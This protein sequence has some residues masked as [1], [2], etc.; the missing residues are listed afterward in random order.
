V[1]T[2]PRG[3]RGA[4]HGP[5]FVVSGLDFAKSIACAI[6]SRTGHVKGC[7]TSDS[8]R[9]SLNVP[10]SCS[11]R[12]AMSDAQRRSRTS[13]GGERLKPSTPVAERGALTAAPPSA[14]CG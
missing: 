5:A 12:T 10:G 6:V 14:P 4:G 11:K 9:G 3:W 1:V 7:G 2:R 13:R 8:I